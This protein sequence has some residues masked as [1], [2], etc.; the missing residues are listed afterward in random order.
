[1]RG[2]EATRKMGSGVAE[3]K[4]VADEQNLFE[5]SVIICDSGIFLLK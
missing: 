1:M 4:V 2:R 5:T 3:L